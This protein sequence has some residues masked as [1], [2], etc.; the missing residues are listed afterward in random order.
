MEFELTSI[1]KPVLRDHTR[2]GGK[3]VFKYRGCFTEGPNCIKCNGKR[4]E[5]EGL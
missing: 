5:N 4:T 2:E 3:V 1:V